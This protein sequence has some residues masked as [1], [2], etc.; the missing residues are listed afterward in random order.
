V[1]RTNSTS[2]ASSLLRIDDGIAATPTE[3][4]PSLALRGVTCVSSATCLAV[5]FDA[6]GGVGVTVSH[7]VPGRAQHVPDSELSSVACYTPTACVAAGYSTNP[8]PIVGVV[9]RLSLPSK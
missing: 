6:T 5:G 2:A 7:G 1:G 4:N 3:V 9:A 8:G